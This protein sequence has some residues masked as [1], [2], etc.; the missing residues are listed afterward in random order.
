ML[1]AFLCAK[2]R[3]MMQ[4]LQLH[5]PHIFADSFT[6][7]VKVGG[8]CTTNCKVKGFTRSVNCANIN[9]QEMKS[10][11][12]GK[13]NKH[14]G[15]TTVDGAVCVFFKWLLGRLVHGEWAT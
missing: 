3:P 15:W 14:S 10:S 2:L 11:A 1:G 4:K 8:S 5:H 9:T 6:V 7:G 12:G 13:E